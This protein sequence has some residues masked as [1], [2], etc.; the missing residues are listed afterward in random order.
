MLHHMERAGRKVDAEVPDGQFARAL[1]LLA[2]AVMMVSS[3][4]QLLWENRGA[5]KLLDRGDGLGRREIAEL[6]SHAYE[7][8]SGLDLTT[9]ARPSGRK[10]YQIAVVQTAPGTALIFIHDPESPRRCCTEA[11]RKLY[12]FTKAEAAVA[13]AMMEGKTLQEIAGSLHVSTN[14]V[15]AHLK[16]LFS[17]TRTSRQAELVL[18][19]GTGVV[20]MAS[21]FEEN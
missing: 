10:P 6:L 11:L 18:L 17:K 8:K 15:R 19:L 3:S 9:L 4:G 14:T 12:G 5:R 16:R 20:A 21:S 2:P 7:A 1:E 13:A